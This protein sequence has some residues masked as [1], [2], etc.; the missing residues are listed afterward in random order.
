MAINFN[1][2]APQNPGLIKRLFITGLKYGLILG[3][4]SIAFSLLTFFV[5]IHPTY[6]NLILSVF[7]VVSI[8]AGYFIA[9]LIQK[10][11]L[12]EPEQKPNAVALLTNREIE[13]FKELLTHKSNR[14]ISEELF[15]E[16]STLKSHI[17]RI[18]KKAEVSNR[19]ELRSK[20]MG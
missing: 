17:N 16:I 10:R 8:V 2:S 1:I 14:E 5:L 12:K 20:F 15:I 6:A 13:V 9:Q 4:V 11:K 7:C 3:T 19:T 18:Y